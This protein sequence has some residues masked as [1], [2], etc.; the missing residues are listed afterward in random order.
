MNSRDSILVCFQSIPVRTRTV[1][2]VYNAVRIFHN[3]SISDIIQTLKVNQD[4][5][6]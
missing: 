4:E 6:Q 3:A 5:R 2:L 1:T